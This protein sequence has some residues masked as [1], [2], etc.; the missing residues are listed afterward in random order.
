MR[1]LVLSPG[2]PHPERG[3]SVVLFHHYIAALARSGHDLTHLCLHEGREPDP[4]AIADHGA[5]TGLVPGR[6]LFA[7]AAGGFRASRFSV[8]LENGDPAPLDARIA[9]A[10]PD[11]ILAFDIHAAALAAGASAARKIVWLGDL[12]FQSSWY[13]YLYGFRENPLSLRWL[14]YAWAQ[15]RAWARVYADV[16]RHFETVIV[17]SGSS[18]AALAELGIASRYAP[19]P[20]PAAADLPAALPPKPAMPTFLFFGNLTGLGS[21]SALHFMFRKV[22]PRLRRLWG[23]GGFRLLIAGH[24]DLRDFAVRAIAETPELEFL[25]FVEDLVGLIRQCHA[26]LAPMDVPVGNRS[27]ILTAMAAGGLVIAHR[28][29]SLG[30]PALVDG[31]TARLFG[32]ADEMVAQMRDAFRDPARQ[33]PVIRAAHRVYEEQFSPAAASGLFVSLLAGQAPAARTDETL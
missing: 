27:R 25:G 6:T 23:R 10:R 7:C 15:R 32:T 26:V 2:V 4:A 31:Q 9:A 11:A 20:W 8:R 5:R 19:Y 12:Q 3:A 30:N 28:N 21:R 14:P 29:T 16:L 1:V 18:V 17:S 33:M 24:A 13:N 22:V